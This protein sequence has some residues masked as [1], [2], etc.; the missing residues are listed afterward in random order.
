MADTTEIAWTDHT[1]NPWWGCTRV[2]PGCDNCYAAALDRRTG[3]NHWED[4]PKILSESNWG[5][6]HTWNR[7]AEKAGE[8]RRVFC[9]S[10]CDWC[11]KGAP[12]SQRDRLWEVIRSTPALDW[13]LL[14]K[15]APR[16]KHCLPADWEGGYPN[17]WL[18]VTVEDRKHGLPRVDHLR[19]V[20]AR[21]RFL[22]VEP[23]LE[24]L[25]DL[26]LTGIHWVIVGG[27]SGPGARPMASEWAYSVR[28][29]CEAQGVPF[30]F[31]QWGAVR[32]KGG[33]TMDG[34]VVTRWP[35]VS[36][37]YT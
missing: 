7:K 15:R 3:G 12:E 28:R 33:K 17:V 32:G 36:T 21:V 24:D 14:T 9:G 13:Q 23:L 10:M 8:R 20:P 16:I 22:S 11:D 29:Q 26:D 34:Q 2:A 25:G 5:K 1:F 35:V 37:A 30:F 6:P 19:Q 18:G 31:K 27:E 4:P